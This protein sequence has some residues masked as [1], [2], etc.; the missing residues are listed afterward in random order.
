MY[1]AACFRQRQTYI[2]P[3]K[4]NIL[5]S[6]IILEIQRS[7]TKCITFDDTKISGLN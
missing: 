4:R 3:V 1:N 6:F 2:T 5:L 7:L